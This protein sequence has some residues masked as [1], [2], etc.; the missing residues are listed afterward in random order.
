MSKTQ[1]ARS[2]Q[3]TAQA[4]LKILARIIAREAIN[5]RL[6]KMEVVKPGSF[7]VDATHAQ[8][9]ECLRGASHQ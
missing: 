9:G 1:N 4:G 2:P 5:Y 8:I 6:A 7:F 3:E